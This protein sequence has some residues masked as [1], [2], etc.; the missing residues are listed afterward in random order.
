MA[1]EY[2]D[3]D[4]RELQDIVRIGIVSS[5]NEKKLT[6]RVKIEEQD[7]VTGDLKIIQNTPLITVINTE[8]GTPWKHRFKYV[9][10]DGREMKLEDNYRKSFPDILQVEEYKEEYIEKETF[11]KEYPDY[12]ETWND[13][14]QKQEIRVFPWIPYIGQWVLCIFKPSGEGDGFIIGGI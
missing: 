5:V 7:I 8:G 4:I 3:N 1:S 14:G 10:Y 12:L 13:T 2:D 9:Q 6:A 11:Q